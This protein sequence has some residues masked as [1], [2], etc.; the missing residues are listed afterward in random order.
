MSNFSFSKV[1]IIESLK[2]TD[3]KSGTSLC[4][5]INGL[6]EDNPEAPLAELE[7]VQGC[8]GFLA[9]IRELTLSARDND[10]FPILHIETH[11]WG[12]KSGLAFADGSSLGWD[13]LAQSLG[14]LNEAT[15]FNLVVCV[16]ACFGGH[17]VGSIKP[18]APAPCFALVGPTHTVLPDEL[19]RSFRDFY[20]ALLTTPTAPA[21]LQALLAHR[22]TV[23]GFLTTSVED[24]FFKLADAYLRNDCTPERLKER[25]EKII[26]Q[27]K[28]ESK[29]VNSEQQAEIEK[30]GET[31]AFGFLDRRFSEFFMIEEI[32]E[33]ADRFAASLAKAKAQAT[34]FFNAQ[35]PSAAA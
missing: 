34:S 28:R 35:K 3:F 15:R 30:I 18:T 2:P 19:L 12:D 25:A 20:R 33:N 1:T 4:E 23:G 13:D 21:A 22:L 27:L 31:L 9:K 8:D 17:F 5:S 6:R 11:G 24:W 32:P 10:E 16:A 7:T 14:L 29:T 26:E